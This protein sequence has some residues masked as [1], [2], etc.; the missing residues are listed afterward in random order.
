MKNNLFLLC[1]LAVASLTVSCNAQ[2]SNDVLKSN[3]YEVL[4]TFLN[5][6]EVNSYLDKHFFL[7]DRVELFK[8]KYL[9]HRKMFIKS[10]S[11]CKNSQDLTQRKVSCPIADGLKLYQTILTDED[12]EFLE[13][14]YNH[15]SKK[16]QLDLESIRSTSLFRMHSER[17]YEGVDYE[18][19]RGTPDLG[20][21]PSIRLENL[22]YNEDGS[23]AI[24]AY[25]IAASPT[26]SDSNFYIL[27][28]MDG[29]WWKPVGA[30]RI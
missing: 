25:S 8:G 28:K 9:Q 6:M 20:E 22:F 5:Q 21:F 23:I 19:Y 29:I 26:Q 3:D 13:K 14:S 15:S 27:R 4:N 7:T 17:Y 11:I 30:F 10:D 16:T 12:L 1:F 18:S 24:V 2:E